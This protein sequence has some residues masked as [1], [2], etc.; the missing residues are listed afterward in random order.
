MRVL[1]ELHLQ[2]DASVIYLL[3]RMI[4]GR[5]NLYNDERINPLICSLLYND[6]WTDPEW[7]RSRII[8][9]YGG[10]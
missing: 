4:P 5:D 8:Q 10:T 3:S 7:S 2:T 1:S 6:Y 9:G